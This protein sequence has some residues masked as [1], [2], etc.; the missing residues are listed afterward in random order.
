ME[1][2]E[3][4]FNVRKNNEIYS[5]AEYQS[6]FGMA[7]I[8]FYTFKEILIYESKYL[9]NTTF[10]KLIED[11]FSKVPEKKLFEHLNKCKYFNKNELMF[12]IKE[13]IFEKLNIDDKTISDYLINKIKDTTLMLMNNGKLNSSNNED[14]ATSFKSQLIKFNIYVK[15]KSTFK[16]L[17]S[18]MEEYII[19]NTIFI[20]KPLINK[21]GYYIYKKNTSQLKVVKIPEDE[22]SKIKIEFF[23]RISAYCNANNYLF[24]YEGTNMSNNTF[25]SRFIKKSSVYFN[26][27]IFIR[28]N[29]INEEITIISIKFPR[30]VLHSMIFIPEKYIFI[31]GGKYKKEIKDVLIYKIKEDNY[32]YEKYP[33]QLPYE[34]LEPSLI[35]INNKYLYAFENSKEKFNVVKCNIANISPFEDIKIKN[36]KQIEQKFFGVVP[37]TIKN[38]IVFLGGQFLNFSNNSTQKNYAFNFNTNELI[39]TDINFENFDFMEKTFIPLEKN[40][41]MQITEFKMNNEYIPKII[42]FGDKKQSV[43]FMDEEE[44]NKNKGKFFE[45]G[46]DS[47]KSKSIKIISN[48][49]IQSSNSN[50]IVPGSSNNEIF[51]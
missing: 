3:K 49:S 1:S 24:I 50:C 42:I 19:N 17:S 27:N 35:M 34:L 22:L 47:V 18:N 5:S 25:T 16:H 4:E 21:L 32:S 40:N 29:L 9:L 10:K 2:N 31:I 36:E 14:I 41:Y 11:F 6:N 20:G 28:I 43:Q 39:V 13:E 33:Y 44:K 12:F 26:N 15:Y 23:S 38:K 30:R 37:K 8:Y 45:K 46:F 7:K 48:Q 51:V